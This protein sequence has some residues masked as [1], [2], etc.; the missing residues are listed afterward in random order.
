MIVALAGGVGAA[1][2]LEGM[3][4]VVDPSSL[5]AVCNVAD[6]MTH[7]GLHISPD[8][9]TVTYTLAGLSNQVT[10]WGLADETWTVMDAL[11]RRG[12][13]DWFRLGDK[14]LATHLYR[15]HR[16]A[17]GATLSQV[18]AEI[19]RALG[20]PIRLLP[21]T[22]D[23][24]ATR[25]T[26]SPDSPVRAGEEVTFQEYFVRLAHAVPVARL[27]FAGAERATPAPGVLEAIEGAEA[28]VICPSNPLVSIGPL[29][30]VAPVRAALERRRE[31]VVGVSPIIAGAAVKGPADRLLAELGHEPSAR[32]VAALYAPFVGTLVID[33]ADSPLAP[34]IE[35]LGVRCVVAPTLMSDPARAAAL[36]R[37]VLGA[38]GPGAR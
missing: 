23:P 15:S 12:G 22:D 30:A 6:D 28:V 8:I 37:T 33:T 31:S 2:L 4:D 9:D 38:A 20:V 29:L 5:V 1:R 19:G 25:V 3:V 7:L 26:L 14:D 16:L 18:T 11:G 35:A 34:A 21:V 36:A 27:R 32:G 17:A 24:L 13:E 10:G